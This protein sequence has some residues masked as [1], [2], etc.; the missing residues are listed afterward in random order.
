[1]VSFY[2]HPNYAGSSIQAFRLSGQLQRLAL[3]PMIVSANLSGGPSY[4]NF[5]GIPLWRL[6]VSSS[7]A[8]QVPSFSVALVRFLIRHRREYDVIHAHGT[9]QH[10]VAA[11][12]G[13]LL[14]KPAILKVAMADSDIAF[15]RQGRLSG[16]VNRLLVARFDRYIATTEAIA[17]EFP[18]QGLDASRVRLIPNGVDTDTYMPADAGERARLRRELGLPDGPLVAFVGVVNRRKN[19][20]GILRIF[21]AAVARGAPGHLIVI[22]PPSQQAHVDP[23]QRELERFVADRGLGARVSF[24]GFRDPVAPYLRASDVFLFPSRQEGMPNCVLEAMACGLPPLVSRSAGAES[25]VGDSE[26]GRL[27]DITDEAGF[28]E[29]LERLL[30]DDELRERLGRNAR[31]RIMERFSLGAIA[32]RYAALYRELLGRA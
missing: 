17:A 12:V 11:F 28:A 30:R 1:M 22:G 4:E 21:E 6:P 25:I 5:R 13:R 23:Y 26:H 20:D 8:L 10:V 18:A 3:Q 2:F 15:Q 31:A 24:L 32:E 29:A 27:I 19:V 7:P 16:R 14:G 9:M